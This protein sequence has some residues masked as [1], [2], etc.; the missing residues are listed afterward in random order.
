MQPAGH[1]LN[2]VT[3]PGISRS[4]PL[5]IHSFTGQTFVGCS[6]YADGEP[7]ILCPGILLYF[8]KTASCFAAQADPDIPIYLLQPPK[9]LR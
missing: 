9:K 7:H 3:L 2:S 8:L 5:F 4:P 6:K 1:L